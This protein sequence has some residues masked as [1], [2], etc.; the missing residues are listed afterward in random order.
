MSTSKTTETQTIS[1]EDMAT[2]YLDALQKVHDMVCFSLAGAR[3]VSERDYDEISQQL[4]VMPRQ[5]NRMP[6]ER[7]KEASEQWLLRNSLADSLALVAPLMEDTRTL[8]E[9]CELRAAGTTDR[10]SLDQ[11]RGANRDAFLRLAPKEK[12]ARLRERFDIGCEVEP[13]I[14]ALLAVTQCLLGN[15]GRLSAEAAGE[16]GELRVPIRSVHLVPAGE[17]E[18]RVT[19]ERSIE[20]NERVLA[21]GQPIRFSRA[22][23]IGAILTVGMFVGNLLQ[24]LQEYAKKTGAAS[25]GATAH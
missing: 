13:H 4:Q 8:C 19:L 9:L 3:M 12:F 6:F 10:A 15:D 7:A 17:S 1:L 25:E 21:V 14:L 5:Q 18:G 22:E 24:G 2:R 11:V 16:A 23:L 20:D